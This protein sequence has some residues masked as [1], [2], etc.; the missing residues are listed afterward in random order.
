MDEL[1][2]RGAEML[3]DDGRPLS[4]T[5]LPTADVDIPV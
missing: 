1:N 4:W 3:R 5:V 2:A